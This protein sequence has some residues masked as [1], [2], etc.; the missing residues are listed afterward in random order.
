[1][2]GNVYKWIEDCYHD[3]YEGAPQDGSAWFEGADC[4]RRVIRGGSWLMGPPYLRS[5][6]R[7]WVSAAY[8][9]LLV[10]FRVG[11]TLSTGG[12]AITVAPGAH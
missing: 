8:Q 7:H 6:H 10:G 9:G 2:H 11:R 1:M 12:G 3:D 4:S 5:A